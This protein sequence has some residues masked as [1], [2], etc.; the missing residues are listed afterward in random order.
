MLSMKSKLLLVTAFLLLLIPSADAQSFREKLLA[1][2]GVI[3][4]EEI[5][6]EE[7][8]FEEKYLVTIEQPVNW[9][10]PQSEMFPQ[11]F[12]IG[13]QSD[14]SPNLFYLS[15]Y[16]LSDGRFKQDDRPELAKMYNTNYIRCE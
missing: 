5:E 4:V 13:Y 9:A 12:E 11:R 16:M 15:G 14:D 1:I 6:Q 10:D 7:K 8:V 2:D 3:S